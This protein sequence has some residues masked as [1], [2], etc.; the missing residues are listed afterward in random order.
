MMKAKYTHLLEDPNV[1]R[2]YENVKR[3][4]PIWADICLRRVGAFCN[5]VGTT[6]V[7]LVAMDDKEL[8]NLLLDYVSSEEKKGHAGTYINS[9]LTAIKSW[10]SFNN[11][12]VIGKIRIRDATG[13]PS[14]ANERVPTQ[15]ELKR[16]FLS[17]DKK[18]RTACVL[19]GHAG[20]RPESIGNYYGTDGL[21]VKDIPDIE[22]KEKVIT[23]AKMPAMIVVRPELSK[24]RQQYFT[25]LSEEGCGYL[26]DYLEE[27]MQNGEEITS[28]SPLVTPKLRMKPFIRTVNI[29]D[30]I[31]D[32]IRKAGFQWRPYVLRSYFDTQLMVAESK[33]LV[34][35]DYRT[36][37]MGHKG[38]IEN[39]YTTNRKRLPEEAIENMREAYQ[40]S[41]AYLQTDKTAGKDDVDRKIQRA[42]L[43]ISGFK[44]E[45][46]EDLHPSDMTQDELFELARKK[47][48]ETTLNQNKQKVVSVDNVAKHIEQGWEFV[49]E[50]SNHKA[51]IRFPN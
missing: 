15:D 33:G 22:I 2:W 34:I 42:V 28:D 35:R 10:L 17:G 40:R 48:T 45:E 39:R 20:V 31:R 7:K 9:A 27:R 46:I 6:P 18:T 1:K 37:W 14:L 5:Q 43:M 47:L 44:E 11:K 8:F 26:K 49:A 50:L 12:H 3:G 24:T 30:I 36:F 38:D 51:V 32:A 4:S 16:I 23:F 29:G 21:R 19:M 25:F 41:Q 13:T